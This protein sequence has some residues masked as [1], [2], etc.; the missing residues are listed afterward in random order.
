MENNP[1]LYT[2]SKHNERMAKYKNE[3]KYHKY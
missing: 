1:W 2:V 3:T